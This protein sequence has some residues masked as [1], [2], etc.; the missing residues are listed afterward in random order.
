MAQK[1]QEQLLK[2]V[3]SSGNGAV[4]YVPK[5]WIGSQ[6]VVIRPIE[7]KSLRERI[8]EPL[9]DN[10]EKVVGVYLYGSYARAEQTKESDIDVL[11]IA[12]E[13]FRIEKAG[14]ISYSMATLDEIKKTIK[15]NSILA[16]PFILEAKAV[17]NTPLLEELRSLKSEMNFEWFLQ[18]TGQIL[19]KHRLILAEIERTEGQDKQLQL[20]NLIYSLILRLRGMFIVKCIYGGR[21]YSSAAFLEFLGKKVGLVQAKLFFDIYRK[22]RDDRDKEIETTS[23]DSVKKL[24]EIAKKE[25]EL[26]KWHK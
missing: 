23:V 16:M 19:E 21:N 24:F 17:I 3:V 8:V 2:P 15:E 11:V 25:F 12:K 10:M 20:G 9:I 1:L 18:S 4:V 22:V 5:Q 7:H 6:V 26:L 14:N 13:K